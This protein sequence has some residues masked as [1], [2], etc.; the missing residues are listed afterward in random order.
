M[1]T[2]IEERDLPEEEK[3]NKKEELE[4]T[5]SKEEPHTLKKDIYNPE[6]EP[7]TE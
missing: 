3:E 2:P 6:E 4:S 1:E 7:K 5:H